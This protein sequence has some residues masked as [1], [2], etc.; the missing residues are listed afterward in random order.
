ML[1]SFCQPKT[2]L[3]GKHVLNLASKAEGERIKRA[4]REARKKHAENIAKVSGE[5]LQE[6]NQT[7]SECGMIRGINENNTLHQSHI[8]NCLWREESEIKAFKD[9]MI[10]AILRK[11]GTKPREIADYRTNQLEKTI[12]I[13]ADAKKK[14]AQERQQAENEAKENARKEEERL[15]KEK[16]KQEE[17]KQKREIFIAEIT[18]ALNQEPQLTN[19]ELNRLLAD[20]QAR[21]HDKKTA[22]KVKENLNKA[23][24][25][26]TEKS[27]QENKAEAEN[28]KKEKATENPQKYSEEAKQKIEKKLKNNE[29]KE[30][31]LN[32]ENQTE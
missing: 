27:Y 11:G 20:I 14:S 19:S 23:Q 21:R 9:K 17:L 8:R 7:L 15:K 25:Q 26:E 13:L 12:E 32:Q 29:I 6:I 4:E 2:L 28:L 31:E 5:P 24:E 3:S 10:E 16:A 30:D 1:D 22:Q 18:A